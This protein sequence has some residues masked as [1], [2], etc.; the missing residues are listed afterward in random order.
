MIWVCH[1]TGNPFVRAL[2]HSL[3]RAGEDYL[4]YTTIAV[5]SEGGWA[6]RLPQPIRRESLRRVFPVPPARR[7]QRPWR[8]LGRLGAM[9][10]RLPWLIRHERGVFSVDAVC[11][12][13]DRHVARELRRHRDAVEAVYAYEDGALETFTVARELGIRCCY[14]LPIAYWETTQRLLREEAVRWPAWEPTLGGTRDAAEKLAR[15]TRELE[16]ADVV[17]CPSKFV[18]DSLPEAVRQGKRCVVAEFG[19]APTVEADRSV[20]ENF[21]RPLQVLFAGS[22]SQ[23][24]GLADLF[25][26]M[27]RLRRADIE[28]VVMGS[29]VVPLEFYRN[30]YAGFRH[31]PP[32]PHRDVLALMRRCDVLALPSIVEGRAL[33]QQEAMSSGLPLVVTPNAG[34]EDLIEEGETGFLVPIRRPDLLAEKLAWFADHRARLPEMGRCARRKAAEYTWEKYGQKIV[35]LLQNRAPAGRA[36]APTPI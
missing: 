3:E 18:F 25:A 21:S 19:S 9:T 35:R 29:P 2:L 30:Q 34:G 1:P 22:L 27:N 11:R 24:K 7:R 28:L 12:D 8:E 10:C 6:R 14:E 33:V 13:L 15:K 4:F 16:L 32:R 5:D 26:A 23:R 17:I 20:A 31:E 36:D